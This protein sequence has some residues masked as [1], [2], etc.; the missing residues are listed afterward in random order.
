VQDWQ[1]DLS[2]LSDMGA[3]DE[4]WGVAGVFDEALHDAMQTPIGP[5]LAAVGLALKAWA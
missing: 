3:A 5:R 4:T 2:M 1:F